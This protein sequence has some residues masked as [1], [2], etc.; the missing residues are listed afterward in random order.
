LVNILAC[1]PVSVLKRQR[2]PPTA[3]GIVDYQNPDHELMKRL[4]P[5]QSVEEV[6]CANFAPCMQLEDNSQCFLSLR[7]LF[8]KSRFHCFIANSGQ[9]FFFRLHI[10]HLDNRHLGLWK[11]CQ[12]Q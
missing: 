7:V 12:G 4:R 9:A 3:L 8:L 5:A 2:T 1:L 6:F 11:T 10:Q